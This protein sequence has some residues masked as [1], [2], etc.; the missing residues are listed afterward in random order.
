MDETAFALQQLASNVAQLTVTVAQLGER[1]DRLKM[2]VMQLEAMLQQ[3]QQPQQPQVMSD[4]PAAM[5][6]QPQV[7]PIPRPPIYPHHWGEG[8]KE[9]E[10]RMTNEG[11]KES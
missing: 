4:D 3:S 6:V 10:N 5:R 1:H 7:Q 8:E 9:D 11:G 2:R